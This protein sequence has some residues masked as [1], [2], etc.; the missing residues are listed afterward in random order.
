MIT[1]YSTGCPKCNVLKSK[2][3]DKKFKYTI[4][5]DIEIMKEKNLNSAP[6]LEVDE[7]LYNFFEALAWIKE[8]EG[9]IEYKY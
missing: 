1:L 8:K 4:C 3:N 7:K 2:L 5:E 9:K 6:Y